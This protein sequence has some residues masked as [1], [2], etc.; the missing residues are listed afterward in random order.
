MYTHKAHLCAQNT[1]IPVGP[2]GEYEV[3]ATISVF[4]Y[5]SNTGTGYIPLH[6]RTIRHT[7]SDCVN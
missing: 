7:T 5:T 3:Y 6:R 4:A 1:T 2:T